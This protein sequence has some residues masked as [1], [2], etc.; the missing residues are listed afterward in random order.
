MASPAPFSTPQAQL[1]DNFYRDLIENANDIIY[2]HDLSGNYLSLNNAA[3]KLIGYTREELLRMNI[4]Q[5]VDPASLELVREMISKKLSGEAAKTGYEVNCVTKDGQKITLEVVTSLVY[6]DGE[7]VAVEGIARDITDRKQTEAALR[8]AHSALRA[9]FGAMNDVI[10]ILDADGRCLKIEET[11]APAQFRPPADLVGKTLDHVLPLD[12]AERIVAAIR[13]SLEKRVSVELDYNTTIRGKNYW[14]VGIISPMLEDT[15]VFVSGDITERKFAE[16][17][18]R[19]SEADLNAAQ[20][21][22]HVG[23]WER[24]YAD[25]HTSF[26]TDRFL[27]SDEFYRIFGFAPQ[28]FAPSLERLNDAIH[29]EDREMVQETLTQALSKQLPFEIRHRVVLPNGE[30][31]FIF[32]RGETTFDPLT[33]RAV[34]TFGTAQDVTDY[35]LAA[36]ARYRSEQRFR[37]LVENANDII[38]THDLDGNFTSLNKA[39]ERISGYSRYEA[40]HKNIADVVAP[41]YLEV[42]QNMIASKNAGE[43]PTVYEI[44]I[45]SKEGRRITLEVSTTLLYLEEEPVGIQG[46]ARDVT[47][48]KAAE[49]ALKESER[50]FRELFENANDLVCTID[51]TGRFITL[52]RAGETII[53]YSRT[54]ALKLTLPEIATPDSRG[55][56]IEF[57]ERAVRED[58]TREVEIDVLTGDGRIVSIEISARR[59]ERN[60]D[61]VGFQCIGRD[62]TE[63]K[64]T[65]AA[66]HNTI[67]LLNSTFESTADGIV[68]LDLCDQLVVYNERFVEMWQIPAEMLESRDVPQI[69]EYVMEQIEDSGRLLANFA[70]LSA[71]PHATSVELIKGRD[72]RYFERYSQPQLM[73]GKPV[74]RVFAY[75]DITERI[76]AEEK[77]RYEALH[78]SLTQLPNRLEFT[79]LLKAAI[80]RASE[81]SQYRFAVLFLDLDRFK[82]INDSLGHVIGDKLIMAVAERFVGC[83]RPGD[84]VARFGGDEFTILLSRVLDEAGVRHVADRLLSVLAQPFDIDGY[85]VFTSASIG[86]VLSDEFTGSVDDFLRDADVAMY[87]AKEAGK[88]RYKIFDTAIHADK[89]TSHQLEI[90]L[91]RAIERDELEV[92]YQPIVE[93]SNGAV[94]EFEAL[95]RWHHPT[96]GLLT[97]LSFIDVAE[98]T[99]LIVP[100]GCWILEQACRQIA[101]WRRE[102][103]FPLSVSVN[104]SAKQ[105]AHPALS[106]QVSTILEETDLEPGALKLEVTE[107]E[108]MEDAEHALSVLSAVTK[109]GVLLASDDFGTG[110]SSLSYLHRFP[111]S[112]LK[113]DKS[114]IATLTDNTKS[115]EIVK[116]VLALA[117]NLGVDVVAEGVETA[118]QFDLLRRLGCSRGQGF[119]FFHPL[120]ARRARDAISAGRRL[121]NPAGGTRDAMPP[122]LRR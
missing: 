60:D 41:E 5:I 122:H 31:R 47:Q 94:Q 77:L 45:I 112:R 109:S 19:K 67:S 102:V 120:D 113:I 88:A 78:D 69:R 98:E 16:A 39:G 55:R 110:Y 51:R 80:E 49:A 62:I 7:A 68:V 48:R 14:L 35:V 23:S 54:D 105:L 117:Q 66:I 86:I 18:L 74:G 116:T 95:V 71:N 29:P 2:S 26:D 12:Q 79:N 36:E 91:R 22:A 28:Q 58:R 83:L 11:N 46:I 30:K 108:V 9:V 121:R 44:E 90:D 3:E 27:W 1:T 107:S 38:Y 97:P 43:N 17:A 32:A 92:F 118:E 104:L 87:R 13:R 6:Q 70:R 56:A 119:Y 20:K 82:V 37:E 99:G 76:V 84:V 81:N 57:C 53:G 64:R 59:L 114:F 93:L 15:V 21:I 75:R 89:I 101:G 72:G 25:P 40:F 61:V 85:E 34:R 42:A 8:E 24:I 33:G 4:R 65:E 103:G 73:Q 10:L 96:R 111:F 52:N 115:L 63:R 50:Q 106:G 100:I